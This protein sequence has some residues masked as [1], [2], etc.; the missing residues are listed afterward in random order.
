MTNMVGGQDIKIRVR[1]LPDRVCL[2][3]I[4]R[5]RFDLNAG[6]PWDPP[7]VLNAD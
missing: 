5:E 3:A 2:E 4:R 7:P 1:K 6:S